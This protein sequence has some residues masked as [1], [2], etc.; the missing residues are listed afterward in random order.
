MQFYPQFYR[1]PHCGQVISVLKDAGVQ[2]ICCGAPMQ[3]LEP[4]T[5]DASQEKHVPVVSREGDIVTVKIGGVP[6]PMQEDHHIEWIYLHMENGG[7]RRILAV[8]GAPEAK[9]CVE[10]GAPLEVFAYCNLHGL[11]KAAA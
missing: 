4:N 10:Q 1:C 9:F 7:Q 6:H 5:A 3:K 2:I 11:W 8:P